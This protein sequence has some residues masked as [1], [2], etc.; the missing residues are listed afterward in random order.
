MNGRE[1]EVKGAK[2]RNIV[3]REMEE[4][5]RKTECETRRSRCGQIKEAKKK[6]VVSVG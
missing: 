6:Q 2:E 4:K 3:P 1:I 5:K